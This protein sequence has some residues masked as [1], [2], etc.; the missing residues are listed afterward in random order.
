MLT[1]IVRSQSSSVTS[2]SGFT[3]IIPAQI[4]TV[5]SPPR[6]CG[7]CPTPARTSVAAVPSTPI[8]CAYSTRCQAGLAAHDQV[9]AIVHAA[10]RAQRVLGWR[11]RRDAAHR[12]RL[13]L[14]RGR[15]HARGRTQR[16]TTGL[17]AVVDV[18]RLDQLDR[19]DAAGD[20]EATA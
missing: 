12:F 15:V 6:A 3:W 14:E 9:P 7:A 1:S 16:A 13:Q 4:T 20:A 19:H 10:V 5:S 8:R 11:L 17:H 2:A 18:R